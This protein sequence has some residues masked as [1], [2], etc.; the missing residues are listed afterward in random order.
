MIQ[1]KKIILGALA[2]AGMALTSLAFLEVFGPRSSS[3]EEQTVEFPLIGNP[4][5]KVEVILFEDLCCSGCQYFSKEIY[6][7]I[8]TSYIH[9]GKVRYIVIPLA[10][11]ENSKERGNAA[12]AVFRQ[13]PTQFF[14]YVRELFRFD[15]EEE[16]QAP[17]LISAAKKI[18]KIDLERLE[19]SIVN[20][21]YYSVLDR[22]MAWAQKMM[23]R[24]FG[25]PALFV[26]GERT[27]IRSFEII[28]KQIER[29][30]NPP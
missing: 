1:R 29:S 30:L 6:P 22:N 8:E 24:N 19:E 9:S 18:G 10:F 7:Q 4:H 26:N 5:A 12:W 20:K 13:N 3:M 11:L 2:F 16:L 25:T 28:Q 21:S 23:R 17:Q 14:P 15:I 27:S